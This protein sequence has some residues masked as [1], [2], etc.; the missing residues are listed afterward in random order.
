[1]TTR[2]SLP[3]MIALGLAV[4]AAGDAFAQ[5]M[6]RGGSTSGRGTS[7]SSLFGNRTL[8]GGIQSNAQRQEAAQVGNGQAVEQIQE[9]AGS[10]SGDERFLRENRQPGAF[11]GADTADAVNLRSQM[12][13]QQ[14]QNF[15]NLFQ[16]LFGNT[17]IQN[18]N[19]R[20][21]LRIPISLG[22]APRP[23]ATGQVATTF[24]ARLTRLPEFHATG[25]VEVTMEGRTAVLRGTVASEA[26]RE[27]AED[28]AMLEP[29]VR[30]VR[31]ELVVDPAATTEEIPT[32]ATL[33]PAPPTP[34][35]P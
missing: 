1:M 11:V 26:D 10:L 21:Q 4:G 17:N 18:Q 35:L 14:Q 5:S 23:I 7:A 22:F 30:A 2:L 25:P 6:T 16:N 12:Q 24:T 9:G 19:P 13:G 8:G 33:T 28:L 29:A 32:P 31:N 15:G 34:G 27:L 20:T 3:L